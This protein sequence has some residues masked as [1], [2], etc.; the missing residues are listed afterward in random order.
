MKKL[1][2][3]VSLWLVLSLR[4]ASALTINI[5]YD[6]SVTGL[7]NAAQVET[8]FATAAQLFQDLYTNEATVYITMYWGPTGPFAGGINLGAS[9][10]LLASTSY[11][12]IVSLLSAHRASIAD[13]NSVASLPASDPTGRPW[14]IPTAEAKVLGLV[15]ANQFED[16]GDVGFA[17]NVNYTFDP[18]NRTVS[19]KYDFIAVA[20]HEISEILGRATARL[21]P[22]FG[23]LVY[24]LFRFTNS[25][26][27]SF[28]PAATNAYFSV[29]NGAT[30]LRSFYT[31]VSMGDIQ[32]WKSSGTPDAYDAFV[33][34]GHLLP[35]STVDI[36]A[37]DVLGYN[38]PG[39]AKPH[40]SGTRLSDG[41]FQISFVNTPGIT[42][43]VLTSTNLALPLTNWTALGTA[44]EGPAG[45]FQFIDT[46]TT[47]KLRFYDVR[48]P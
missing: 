9:D 21:D 4:S 8:A 47:N 6:A 41:T 45:Q 26:E 10:F 3:L 7:T 33:P 27:R 35:I 15:P 38:G 14:F 29:D 13:T 22:N 39:L 43:T 25:A 32:D 46:S 20:E 28:N 37:L 2:C 5:T 16:D 19:G 24:D 48:S 40:L 30:A 34:S 1:I 18:N 36:T 44:T 42:F 31:N 11:S 17:T 12:Q 23:F